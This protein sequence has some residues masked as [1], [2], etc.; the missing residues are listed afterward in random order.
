LIY[1]AIFLKYSFVPPYFVITIF[2]PARPASSAA[3]PG[4]SYLAGRTKV[5]QA[6]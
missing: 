5:S 6:A 4:V 2:A 3:L 1:S